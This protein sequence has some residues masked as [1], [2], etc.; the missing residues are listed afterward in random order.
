MA[1]REQIIVLDN[2]SSATLTRKDEDLDHGDWYDGSPS[3]GII[4][5]AT[6]WTSAPPSKIGP[7]TRAAWGS[8]SAGFMTG[9]A[10]WVT[11]TI[12]GGDEM[13]IEWSVPFVGISTTH[14]RVDGFN[15]PSTFFEVAHTDHGRQPDVA[16]VNWT[17][18]E[19]PIDEYTLREIGS[20]SSAV[21]VGSVGGALVG[22]A[23]GA[24]VENYVAA[25]ISGASLLG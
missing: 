16:F 5:P 3:S 13:T 2:S 18:N 15:G 14:G 22:S 11:Y 24:L 1:S 10:G 25:I 23:G 20:A 12:D 8:Q 19:Y 9:T 7:K 17:N 21:E 6:T 4:D